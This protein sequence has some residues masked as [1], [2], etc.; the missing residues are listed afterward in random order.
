MKL[1]NKLKKIF[2]RIWEKIRLEE[3]YI[4]PITTTELLE[5]RDKTRDFLESIKDKKVTIDGKNII[6]MFKHL[7]QIN[8]NSFNP[9]KRWDWTQKFLRSFFKS[10]SKEYS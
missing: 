10:F 5:Q 9:Y 8:D 2:K 1:L 3:E 7:E 6:A 4:D